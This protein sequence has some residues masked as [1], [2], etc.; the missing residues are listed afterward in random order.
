MEHAATRCSREAKA[1]NVLATDEEL[2][3]LTQACLASE[4]PSVTVGC[5]DCYVDAGAC[6]A[7]HCLTACL[8]GDSRSC[9]ECREEHCAAGFYACAGLADPEVVN[10]DGTLR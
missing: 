4:M 6:T 2:R 5:R 1:N 3:Q 9:D 8:T 10:P 7:D